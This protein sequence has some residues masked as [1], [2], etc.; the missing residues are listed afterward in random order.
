MNNQ[1]FLL[2]VGALIVALLL[3]VMAD[4][5]KPCSMQDGTPCVAG[6]EVSSGGGGG[7]RYVP[8]I[9]PTMR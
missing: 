8:R 2:I 7:I 1:R 3:M 6:G 9:S 4:R 5:Q